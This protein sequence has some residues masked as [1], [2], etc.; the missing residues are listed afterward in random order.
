MNELSFEIRHGDG[1]HERTTARGARVVIGSGAHCDVRLAAGQ[2]AVEHVAIESH[3]AGPLLRNLA[4][5]Q[6]L[7]SDGIALTA[8]PL[9]RP[10]TLRIGATQVQISRPVVAVAD[11]ESHVNAA[12]IAKLAVIAGLVGAIFMVS[13]MNDVEP[14]AE[15]PRMPE[16]FA[17]AAA[18]CPRTDPAEARVVADDERANGDGARERSPFDPREARSAVKSYETAAVCYR[19]AQNAEAS[20]DAA[21]SA[22]QMR[23]DTTLDFRARRVR[24][25]RLLLVKDYELASQDVTV[26]RALTE[27]QPGEYS[28]WLTIVAREIKNQQL[29]N[30]Q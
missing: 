6:A 9:D 4:M 26:L 29:E 20:E 5:P 16:L 14:L 27:G 15:A 28:R 10:I 12:M 30:G 13:R 7:T 24:L 17:P 11:N 25:E 2:A 3:P 8:L 1:R 21:Q 19:L 18:A 23:Q 22:A